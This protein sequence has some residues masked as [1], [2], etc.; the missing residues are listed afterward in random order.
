MNSLSLTDLKIYDEYSSFFDATLSGSDQNGR[1]IRV[2]HVSVNEKLEPKIIDNYPQGKI[3]NLKEC[4]STTYNFKDLL[5]KNFVVLYYEKE[6]EII[7]FSGFEKYG[8]ISS[9]SKFSGQKLIER[10]Y[11]RAGC[12]YDYMDD[13]LFV[14]SF[15]MLDNKTSES[16]KK[17]LLNIASLFD[18]PN[19]TS[20]RQYEINH[21]NQIFN[22]IPQNTQSILIPSI[23]TTSQTTSVPSRTKALPTPPPKPSS[24]NSSSII[25]SGTTNSFKSLSDFQGNNFEKDSD[26]PPE[27]L[28]KTAIELAKKEGFTKF[29][30]SDLFKKNIEVYPQPYTSKTN[31]IYHQVKVDF[32]IEASNNFGKSCHL[33]LQ[34]E[35][36]ISS[37]DKT[38]VI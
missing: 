31:R 2:L 38:V 11:S 23:N 4:N 8:K 28:L 26:T 34:R 20:K 5:N 12:S 36:F 13:K 6:M 30:I 10:S 3:Y 27:Q 37:S 9:H 33:I 25:S 19:D 32:F 17:S 22:K 15:K 14:K 24:N 21:S 35:F 16:V 29:A 1:H 7:A 18:K